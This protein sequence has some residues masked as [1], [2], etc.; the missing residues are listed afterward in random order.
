MCHLQL[1]FTLQLHCRYCLLPL[2]FPEH[3]LGAFSCLVSLGVKQFSSFRA[4]F[5]ASS[6]EEVNEEIQ[7]W[8][9][10]E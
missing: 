6:S 7:E 4:F 8:E 5:G 3:G 2:L 9:L 10:M 1:L